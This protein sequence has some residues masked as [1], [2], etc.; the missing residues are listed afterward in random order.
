MNIVFFSFKYQQGIEP[1]LDNLFS[2]LRRKTDFFVGAS[3]EVVEETVLRSLRAQAE[4]SR[5]DELKKR[6]AREKEEKL[7]KQKLEEKKKK[8]PTAIQ[9]EYHVLV[10]LFDT[11][12]K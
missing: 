11:K 2:F 7:K 3:P 4:I 1:L 8:V 9:L 12:K 10:L 5:K 6:Q